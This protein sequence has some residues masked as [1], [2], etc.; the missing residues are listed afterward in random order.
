[1]VDI[2]LW[3]FIGAKLVAKQLRQSPAIVIALLP[4]IFPNEI[5]GGIRLGIEIDEKDI[6]AMHLR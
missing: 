3:R 2:E 5:D 1:L 6:F 4:F